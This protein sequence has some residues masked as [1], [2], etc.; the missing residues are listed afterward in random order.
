MSLIGSTEKFAFSQLFSLLKPHKRRLTIA[1]VCML[2]AS[3]ATA[4]TAYL[5]KPAMDDIFIKKNLMMLQLIPILFLVINLI[6]GLC[7]WGNDYYLKSV[8]LSVVAHLRQQLYDHIQDLPLSFF[9]RTSTGLLM[10]RITNDVNEIQNAV[11]KGF[12]GLIKDSLSVVG[13]IFVV[14][15]Q[16]W[17]LASIA[18]LIL[19]LAFYPL[20]KFGSRLRKL[21]TKGQE[22]M[23]DLNVVLHETFTGSRIV[24]AFGMESYEK[25]RFFDRN[26]RVLRYYL[27]SEWIDALSSPLMEFIGALAIAIVIGYGGYQVIQG[28]STPGTFFS[29]LGGLL[30]LYR[31]V[32]SIS[33]ANS[34]VQKG[35][36]S[37][38]RVYAVLGEKNTLFEKPDAIDLR[39]IEQGIEFQNVCFAYDDKKVL[40]NISL[41]VSAGQVVALA[42]S[43]G[44]GKT[45]LVNLIPRFYDVS[46][47]AILIDGTDVRDVS[48][49]SLRGQI[50]IVTQQS[51][52][53]NDT[54]RNNIA[55]GNLSKGN[56]D[57]EWAAKAAYAHD[58][59]QELPRG[60]DTIIG[61]QGV[62]LSGGQRQ[63]VCIA[64]AI[65]KDAPILILDEAT[66]SLDSESELEVQMALENLMRGRTTFVIAHRLSTIQKA[67]RILVISDGRIVEE[68]T[69]G[70]LLSQ[71]GEYRR[72]FDIQFMR[73]AV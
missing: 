4:A 63:R 8:G 36:A 35:I 31:P 64:R 66:S 34:V 15:Y 9:D 55:Y 19:P 48:L 50:A 26:Q 46:E 5:I 60:L 67:D 13:L 70:H 73:S 51:F 52:L 6:N 56:D 14:F 32:K 29:F 65:L 40:H 42:G 45:T 11:T 17:K 72:L 12:T 23:A 25:K 38:V 41:S 69:H 27:K 37:T 39:P 49:R 22:T 20:F 62:M 58:F 3:G 47:G 54:I 44:G 68:G 33:K 2:G 1:V 10:S 53:F 24:K 61:E 43:S 18:I 30:M 59:V 28:A 21:A 57:I 7:Q 71:N 16:D